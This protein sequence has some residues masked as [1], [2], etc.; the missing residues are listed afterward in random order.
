MINARLSVVL[1]MFDYLANPS[2]FQRFSARL[3]PWLKPLCVLLFAAGLYLAFFASPA[4]YQ[5]GESVRIMYVHVPAAWIALSSYLGL[6]LAALFYL[7]WR[8]PL[9]DIAAKA[10]APVGAGFAFIT[11][12]TGAFWGKPMWGTWWV[13]DGRLTSMLVL[14]FF[15]IG[16]IALANGFERPE[17]GARPAAI[18]ALVGV[19]NLP[20]VKFSV[21]WWNTLHQPAS[22]LRS[23]G[24]AIDPAML[25]PLFTM[26]AGF[27]LFFIL[28]V[29]MRIDGL[30]AEKKLAN[31]LLQS[32]RG[33]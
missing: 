23:G 17:R 6:G 15:F 19:V 27:Q 8:H 5:Q 24:V 28:I 18:L 1:N 14:F 26:F 11:L 22:I 2:R 20:I 31:L 4:D 29:L 13:W 3:I 25:W 33:R 21:D 9:A 10:M 16:Y 7:V 30:L 12:A 32:Q